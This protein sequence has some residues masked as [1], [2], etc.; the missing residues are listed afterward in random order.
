VKTGDTDD[1]TMNR[2]MIEGM[3]SGVETRGCWEV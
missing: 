2:W 1:K 3:S